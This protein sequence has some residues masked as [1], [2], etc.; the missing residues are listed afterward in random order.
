MQRK[1]ATWTAAKDS[2]RVNRLLRIISHPEWLSR[3]AEITLSSRGSNTPGVDGITKQDLIGELSDY[4]KQIREDLLTDTYQPSPARRVYIPKANGKQR[5]L[6]IPTL[7]DRIVQRA[8]LMAMEPIWENDF[9]SLSYGFRPE[10]S[11][12]HAIRTVKL[13]LTD[14]SETKTRGRWV[15]EGD[16][17]SYF[18]TIHHKLLMQCVRKRISCQRFNSLLWRFIKAGHVER[19][20]FCAASKGVP[21]GGVISPLLSNIM[22]N[23]F[24]QYLDK[25]YLGNKVR[26][27][28][29]YWNN[30]IKIGRTI[31]KEENRQWKPAVAYCRYADDFVIMVKGSK[32][33]A[34]AIR[35]QCREFL[36]GKLKLTLNM[37]KTQITHVNDGF[38]FLGHRLI[39]KRGPKGTMRVVSGIPH[40]KA[41]AFAHSLSKTLSGDY[42]TSKIDK[43]EKLNQRLKGW[44]QFYCYT[45]FTAQVY[46]KIDRIVFWKLGHWLG[47]KY[48]CSVKS[49]LKRW[50]KHPKPNKAKTWVLFGKTNNGNLCGES[51]YRLVSSPKMR[52][53]WRLPEMNPYLRVEER[54]TITSRYTDVAMAVG[55]G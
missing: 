4:L 32:Q 38:I 53:R 18:D 55:H 52:F 15:I 29:W 34:E 48:R 46:S 11:V 9:H 1:L 31:A 6:G 17:S 27:D 33:A 14:I 43:V 28:R 3:A 10:R 2:Y 30:S 44:S 8:M 26:K 5:P 23:E 50:C 16:L 41:K 24:D 45:D 13:Q 19:N 49:L 37:E 54:N 25:C 21:Q 35:E 36:E 22:L 51:L 40:G 42:S 39:R 20:L 12:H 47:S 7:R